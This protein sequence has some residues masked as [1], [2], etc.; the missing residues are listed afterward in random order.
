MFSIWISISCQ[1]HS[2][3][4]NSNKIKLVNSMQSPSVFVKKKQENITTTN[5]AAI[6]TLEAGPVFKSS[7]WLSNLKFQGILKFRV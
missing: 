6:Y 1:L 2:V 7:T 3:V 4:G 5:V